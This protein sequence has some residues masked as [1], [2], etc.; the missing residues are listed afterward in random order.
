MSNTIDWN[1]RFDNI[2]LNS[3]EYIEKSLSDILED[4]NFKSEDDKLLCKDII[5]HLETTAAQEIMNDKCVQLPYIGSV[6]KNPLKK[7]LEENRS[8]FKLAAKVM[9]KEQAKEYYA[10][11]FQEKKDELREEA[12]RKAKLKEVRNKYKK[13]YEQYFTHIG[14]EYA[15]L[16]I[17]TRTMFQ[18]VEFDQEFEDKMRELNE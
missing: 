11:V 3:L 8:S 9:S 13:Q 1:K 6:R 10:S 14:P 15:E 16:F 4:I 7:V 12:Y 2:Q 18:A 17:L 5:M